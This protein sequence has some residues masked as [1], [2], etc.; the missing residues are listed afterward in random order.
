MKS[1]K[2]EK[3]DSHTLDEWECRIMKIVETRI[4]SGKKEKNQRKRH[5]LSDLEC[6]K[7]LED[8]HKHFLL[9]PADKASNNILVVCK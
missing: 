5:I 8:F 3:V 7:Y 9:V 6:N 4:D 1:A 2:K